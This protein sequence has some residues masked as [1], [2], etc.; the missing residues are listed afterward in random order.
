[1]TGLHTLDELTAHFTPEDRA[2]VAEMEAEID[3]TMPPDESNPVM[4]LRL[5]REL[6]D[7]PLSEFQAELGLDEPA[8]L[9]FEESDDA[10]VS[11]VAAY[12]KAT[13][14][15]LKL[16]AEY[17]DSERDVIIANFYRKRRWPTRASSSMFG[18]WRIM[19]AAGPVAYRQLQW[20]AQT[21]PCAARPDSDTSHR[22]D[23]DAAHRKVHSPH[24]RAAL[25]SGCDGAAIARLLAFLNLSDSSPG[26]A[27]ANADAVALPGKTMAETLQASIPDAVAT[28]RHLAD[29][30]LCDVDSDGMSDWDS[31]LARRAVERLM[32][33]PGVDVILA[34]Q[35]LALANPALFVPWDAATQQ[36]FFP[37]NDP[38]D[39]FAPLRYVRFVCQMADAARAIRQDARARHG[40]ADPA[41]HLSAALGI[42]P[43]WPLA[44]FIAEYNR[45][46]LTEGTP[47]PNPDPVPA[48]QPR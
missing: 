23:T 41:A 30:D 2:L 17:P 12:I 27:N 36:T 38:D 19:L 5:L 32:A 11:R 1:M 6:E 47:Y 20:A 37:D 10:P 40:I 35:I 31:I 14:G 16:V 44:R 21:G 3:A 34:S 8:I 33:D 28:L 18:E 43:P 24:F 26:D 46:T 13:G 45:L 25:R 42:S 9:A 29:A 22:A 48:N 4:P 7:I 39:G 15:R